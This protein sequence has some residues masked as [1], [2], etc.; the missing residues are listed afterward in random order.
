MASPQHA[1]NTAFDAPEW[2]FLRRDGVMA[3]EIARHDWSSTPLGPIRQWPSALRIAVGILISS[4]FPKC[5]FWGPEKT[6]IYN[7]AFVPI[8]GHKHPCVGQPGLEVWDE[9]RADIEPIMD[10]AMAGESTFIEDFPLLIDRSG[11][12]EDAFFTFCYSPVR[13]EHGQVCGLLDT[14]I[15]TTAKVRAEQLGKLRN[16]ELVHRSRNAYALVSALINQTFR[17]AEDLEAARRSIQSRIQALVRAQDLLMEE[18]MS[19]GLLGRIAEQS[20]GAF[21]TEGKRIHFSGPDVEI[22]PEQ[23]TALSLALHELGTNATKYGALS[24]GFEGQVY[25]SWG[26]EGAAFRLSWIETGGPAVTAPGSTGFGSTILRS[27][28]PE[29]FAAEATLDFARDGLRL[30]LQGPVS[31]LSG[32][33]HSALN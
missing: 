29:A 21:Q 10:L 17:R 22:G 28:L 16:K 33:A 2:G 7:D 12:P 18:G 25:L 31:A 6:M 19:K 5:L 32:V 15:E 1:D 23:T 30:S 13:D 14:V 9:V 4:D 8:L 3:G 26:V 24:A 11:T 20:L 27:V